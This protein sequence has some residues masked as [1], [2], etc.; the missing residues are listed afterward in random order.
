MER[1]IDVSCDQ[2]MTCAYQRPNE[3][4]PGML[5]CCEE[6]LDCTFYSTCINLSQASAV[7]SL[8]ETPQPLALLCTESTA[9]ACVTWY[10]SDISVTDFGCSAS[11]EG[12]NMLTWVEDSE[13]T[14]GTLWE[15]DLYLTPVGTEVVDSYMAT[16]S[17]D[18]AQNKATNAPSSTPSHS[19]DANSDSESTNT[20]AIAGGVVGGVA[21]VALIGAAGFFI[22]RKRNSKKAQGA[23]GT[24]P[25]DDKGPYSSV[26]ESH[27]A[28]SENETQFASEMGTTE[29]SQQLSEVH[30]STPADRVYEMQGTTVRDTEGKHFTAELPADSEFPAKK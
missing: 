12:I 4:Y 14:S 22:G 13:T 29:T 21:G 3:K 1:L 17:S 11:S 20:G 23:G 16:F 10:Y 28:Y 30:G 25:N 6:G 18:Q 7:P 15:Y 27:S 8:T 24:G 5:G 19:S 26:P 2:G 9:P